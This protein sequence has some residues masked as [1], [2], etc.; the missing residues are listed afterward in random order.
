MHNIYSHKDILL[1][2]LQMKRPLLRF[3]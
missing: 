3:C 1:Q 2:E